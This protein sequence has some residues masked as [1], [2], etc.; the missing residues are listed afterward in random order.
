MKTIA[1]IATALAAALVSVFVAAPA[2]A[3]EE[4]VKFDPTE[5]FSHAGEPLQVGAILIVGF[6]LLI[7]VLLL[8]QAISAPFEKK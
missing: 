8:A 6:V 7:V 2:L 5:Q 3:S 4:G 1:R